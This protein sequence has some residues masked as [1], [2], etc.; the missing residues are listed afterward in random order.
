MIIGIIGLGDM[1]RL[2]ARTFAKAGYQVCGTD[3]PH[4]LQDAENELK[5][6]QID[7][8][9]N[10][11]EVSRRS[12][13]ILYCVE[14][15]KIAKVVEE[16]AKSTKYG[17]IVGGQTSVKFPEIE[18]FER[19]LP[20]DASIVTCHA[21][22]G[23]GFETEGQTMALIRHRASDEIY[24]K[25]YQIF[26]ALK[27]HIIEFATYQEHDKIMADTQA[28]THMGF[29]SMGSA[30]KNTGA[31]PWDNPVYAGGIDN[32]KVL[33]TLRIFS[34]KSHIYAGLA[35]LNPYAREQVRA[36]AKTESKL[37][38]LMIMEKEEEFRK[39]I[40]DA[41]EYVFNSGHEHLVL[42]HEIMKD[43]SLADVKHIRKPN[44]H[45]SILS[46]VCAWHQMQINPYHNLICQTPP[47][48]LR[49]GIAEYLFKDEE[50]LEETIKAA[51]YDKS[52]RADD[53]EFHTAVHEWASII[54]YGDMKGYK[55]HFD[56]AKAFFSE[57]LDEGRKLSADLIRQ[58]ND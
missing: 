49:L 4:L 34:Y 15:E 54:E 44:S 32:V 53:L 19:F 33:I 50:L 37:F 25:T 9:S 23:P 35:I 20:K 48:R 13:L 21:L 27:S 31:Y 14:A 29:E 8:L 10:G 52:I 46:M 43:Y 28:L 30:W 16:Y 36:Y 39:M 1:G 11:H 58:L 47:F 24:Q 18:A 2:Y 3:L 22:H 55:A 45:L 6:F 38:S 42:N 41:K 56:A 12:D 51:I 40:Y 7:I 17:A 57:R 5:S 26:S